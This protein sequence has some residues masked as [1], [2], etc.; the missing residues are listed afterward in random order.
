M[1]EI[2]LP[3]LGTQAQEEYVAAIE[4]NRI[5]VQGPHPP[6]LPTPPPLPVA[7]VVQQAPGNSLFSEIQLF[8]P[9]YFLI[10][11]LRTLS[12]FNLAASG[13][14]LRIWIYHLEF[15]S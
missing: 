2:V 6:P 13:G 4:A 5:R 7:P 9:L 8:L 12:F 15:G 11:I 14:S 3:F 10:K 1:F